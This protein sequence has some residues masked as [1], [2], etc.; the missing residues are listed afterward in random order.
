MYELI[1]SIRH[2]LLLTQIQADNV[3]GIKAQNSE[4]PEHKLLS[5][6]GVASHKT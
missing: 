5:L 3:S 1:E 6:L 4:G 2:W